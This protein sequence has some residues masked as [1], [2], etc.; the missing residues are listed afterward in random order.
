ML[1]AKK[2]GKALWDLRSKMYA[3]CTNRTFT[4]ETHQVIF[5]STPNQTQTPFAFPVVG[6]G[7][8]VS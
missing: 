7:V 2:Y 8:G 1:D 6:K 3:R 4:R 5:D